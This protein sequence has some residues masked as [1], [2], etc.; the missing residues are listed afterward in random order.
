MSGT[1]IQH[2][3]AQYNDPMQ[4]YQNLTTVISD[5]AADILGPDDIKYSV[6]WKTPNRDHG[7]DYRVVDTE[8]LALEDTL[9]IEGQSRGGRYQVVPRGSGPAVIRQRLPDGEIGWEEKASE[10]IIMY[11]RYEWDP[12]EDG[13]LKDWLDRFGR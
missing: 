12:E 13:K 7:S 8:P 9:I 1:E 10:L 4:A 3:Q 11:G 2:D 6:I 5:I